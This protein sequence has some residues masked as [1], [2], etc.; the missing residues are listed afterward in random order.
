MG[1]NSHRRAL[2]A[3]SE[4]PAIK[5][6]PIYYMTWRCDRCKRDF[7]L[8]ETNAHALDNSVVD[9]VPQQHNPVCP[10]GG[11]THYEYVHPLN[12]VAVNP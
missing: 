9:T 3:Q 1:T 12:P 6:A 11:P 2:D 5:P 4:K 8:Y 7:V 10:Y